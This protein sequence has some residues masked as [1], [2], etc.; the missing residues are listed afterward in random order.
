MI[1]P[2]SRVQ[3]VYLEQAP[4]AKQSISAAAQ[5]RKESQPVDSVEL[6]ATAKAAISSG[7]VDHDGDS[8]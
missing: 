7:D 1:N 5:S 6:S 2:V 3:S 8:H 4:V